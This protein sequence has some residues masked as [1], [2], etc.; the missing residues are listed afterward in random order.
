MARTEDA[1][2]WCRMNS[3]TGVREQNVV[4]EPQ[5][6]H[7]CRT[8]EQGNREQNVVGEPQ[9]NNINCQNSRTRNREQ[10]AVGEE[11]KSNT[12]KCNE[13]V[14]DKNIEEQNNIENATEREEHE[15]RQRGEE[16]RMG[17][18]R[19]GDRRGKNAV[20]EWREQSRETERRAMKTGNSSRQ[21]ADEWIAGWR[22]GAAADQCIETVE[23]WYC[24]VDCR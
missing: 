1:T 22:L 15:A 4:G 6:Q 5:K 19:R 21:M 11:R 20:A 2:N 13:L 3:R 23:I 7:Q 10:D 18:G 14:Q 16:R 17:M 12:A 24:V 9:N 8:A